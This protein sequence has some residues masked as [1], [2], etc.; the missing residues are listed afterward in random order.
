GYLQAVSWKNVHIKDGFWGARLQVNREVTLDYQYE[1]MEKTGRIDNFRRASAKKKG[2]FTGSF[3]NDS[4]VYK[5]LEAASYSL[6]THP[7]KKLGHKVDR[8][9]EEISGAQENDGY[10]NTYFILEKEKRFT[11]LVHPKFVAAILTGIFVIVENLI[12]HTKGVHITNTAMRTSDPG[13]IS[14]E[15]SPVF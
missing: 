9:I 10:L 1:R 3:F 11:N 8:L 4:D 7:D 2:K 14:A 5:W 6:G 12:T 15:A 13:T